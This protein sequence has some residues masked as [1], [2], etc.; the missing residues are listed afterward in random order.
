LETIDEFVEFVKNQA[1]F[2]GRMAAKHADN[3]KRQKLHLETRSNFTDL[4]EFLTLKFQ[5]AATNRPRLNLAWSELA[6]LPQELIDQLSV[7]E[8]DKT[9]H[10]IMQAVEQSGGV[11]SLDRILVEYY[12]ITG[13]V[14]KRAQMNN[15][16][17]RMIQ[18]GMMHSVPS[19][20]GVYSVRELTDEEAAALS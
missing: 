3:P 5:E 17:Y 12:R 6:D 9:E 20:K 1:E 10:N 15:R 11:A 14:M 18:K 16:I 7:S 19:K 8:S 2:H 13:D 4:Y